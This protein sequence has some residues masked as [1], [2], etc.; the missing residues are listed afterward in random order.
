MKKNN[1]K[2]LTNYLELY[3]WVYK[4]FWSHKEYNLFAIKFP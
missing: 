3:P 1:N 4:P 2:T